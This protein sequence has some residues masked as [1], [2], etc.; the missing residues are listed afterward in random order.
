MRYLIGAVGLLAL[1]G[2]AAAQHHGGHYGGHVPV[3]HG[4][5]F[6]HANWHHVVPHH[7][8]YAGAYYT[9]GPTHYYTPS[10]VVS[11]VPPVAAVDARPPA[12]VEV[13][14]PVEVTFGGFA[15]YEDLAGRLAFEANALCLDMHY[16]YKHNKGFAEVYREAYDILLAAKYLVG[17]EHKGDK[18]L[19]AK[20]VDDAHKLFHHVQDEMRG[21][22]RVAA[23]QID[24][25]DLPEK[26]QGVEAV[27][28]HLA[29]DVGVKPH[30]PSAEAA[31]TPGDRIEVAP[32]PP[33][34]GKKE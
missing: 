25:T 18:D 21:W 2:P 34:P 7:P 5:Y 27:L 17:K 3:H 8:T 29:Y 15:R 33:P 20:R 14:K 26:L 6:G 31:P 22:T 16:N 4:L 32:P 19:I 13:Q 11:L 24:G 12:P 23:K 30:E 28:H 10:P 1:A 9:V